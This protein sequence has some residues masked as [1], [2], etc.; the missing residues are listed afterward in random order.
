MTRSKK[1][2]TVSRK[3]VKSYG[4]G[5]EISD[6][7]PGDFI[8]THGSAWTS[9]MIRIG[10]SLRIHGGDRKYTWWN[11]AAIFVGSDGAII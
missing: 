3:S 5:E 7:R 6:P 2:F 11:H 10:Q 9:K 4:P 1:A 8:L